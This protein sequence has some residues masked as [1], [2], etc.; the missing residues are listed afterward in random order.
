MSLADQLQETKLFQD[1]D[2]TDLEDLITRMEAKTF[3]RGSV[4]FNLGDEGDA[5][6]IIRSG[7]IRIYMYDRDEEITLR[8]YGKNDIFGELSLLDRQPRSASAAAAEELDVLR[9]DRENFIAFLF[10]RPSIGLA[11]MRSLSQRLR[12]TTDYLEQYKPKR[13][14]RETVDRRQQ[15]RR[16]AEGQQI[17]DILDRVSEESEDEEPIEAMSPI[18]VPYK[19]GQAQPTSDLNFDAAHKMGGVFG[20]LAQIEEE[21]LKLPKKSPTEPTDPDSE[22]SEQ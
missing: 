20:K 10:E 3:P 1:V 2:L 21:T 11:M 14:E 17:A 18:E 12:F 8:Y 7:R 9:L 15:F 6:Y 16:G 5:M 19:A 4:L 13:F 22:S